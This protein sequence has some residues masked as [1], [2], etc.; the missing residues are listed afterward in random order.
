MLSIK[1]KSVFATFEYTDE[2]YK[3]TGDFKKSS[4]GLLQEC[5]MSINKVSDSSF[6]GSANAYSDGST[7]KYNISGVELADMETVSASVKACAQAI[8]DDDTL[9]TA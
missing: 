7:I 2:S 9:E 3:I 4:T 5:G 8:I 6:G 1:E